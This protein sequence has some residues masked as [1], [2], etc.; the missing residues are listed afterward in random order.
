MRSD[1]G[2]RHGAS[3]AV[4][5]IRELSRGG[6]AAGCEGSGGGGWLLAIPDGA[7]CESAPGLQAGAGALRAAQSQGLLPNRPLRRAAS[8]VGLLGLPGIKIF[9]WL[10][11]SAGRVRRIDVTLVYGYWAPPATAWASPSWICRTTASV[12]SQCAWGPDNGTAPQCC[13]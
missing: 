4:A 13:A 3:E 11:H 9:I 7:A 10:I 1:T 5:L 6:T 12:M 8:A 2:D